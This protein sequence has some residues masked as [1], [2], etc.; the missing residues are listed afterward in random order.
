[1]EGWNGGIE[2]WMFGGRGREGRM[3]GWI[4][5]EGNEESGGREEGMEVG[6][7]DR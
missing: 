4:M 5:A 7:G 6:N 2:G 1:M 3:N